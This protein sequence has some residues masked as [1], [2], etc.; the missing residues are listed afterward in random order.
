MAI[1]TRLEDMEIGDKIVCNL[2]TDQAVVPFYL[3]RLGEIISQYNTPVPVSGLKSGDATASQTRGYFYFIYVGDDF[4]G[5]K[6]LIADRNI[7]HSVSWDTLN[8]AGVA[9]KDGVETK[10][11]LDST[12][13]KTNIRLLTGGVSD[14][15]KANSEWDKYI[16]NGT[17]GGKYPA[18]DN[19]TW[20]WNGIYFWTSTSSSTNASHRAYRGNSNV[21]TWY[22]NATTT[23]AAADTGF[24]P[25]LVAESLTQPIVNKYL[26]QDGKEIKIFLNNSWSVIGQAPY[27]HAMFD[28][29]MNDLKVVPAEAWALLEGDFDVVTYT[30]KLDSVQ[31][32]K[33]NATPIGQLVLA[34][35]DFS[36]IEDLTITASATGVKLIASGD[37]GVSWNTYLDSSWMPIEPAAD[38]VKSNGMDPATFNALLV[39]QWEELG[40][41]IRL[42]FYVE[43]A[44]LVDKITMNKKAVSTITPT[45]DRIHISYSAL[46]IEGRLKD[47]ELMNAINMA[48]LEFKTNALMKSTKY[49]L[50]DM[51]IDTCQTEE[52]HTIPS[53][54]GSLYDSVS[55]CY[56]GMGAVETNTEELPEHR[57]SLMVN[58][59]HI[60]CTFKYSLDNGGNWNDLV[61]EKVI[62]ITPE[63]GTQLKIQ[64]H[65]PTVTAE[66]TALSYA[67]A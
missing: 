16:V 24:R 20:N 39:K 7:V 38:E 34:E 64:V 9:T 37:S 52:M 59:N 25:V 3:Y 6:L 41:D 63:A 21:N 31:T 48:K 50:H 22:A 14:A 45:L 56:R 33:V 30:N 4:K 32:I 8:T 18:G 46:T 62:D 19:T 10:I 23:Y 15:L 66:L 54:S 47:L 58:A 12:V 43:D 60:D 27:T 13:W 61:I 1:K 35:T 40:R 28:Q 53:D 51:V 36:L 26:V 67:W 5:R 29:G 2:A 11:G 55:K 57:K 42:G 65:M 49:A 44:G 17:G